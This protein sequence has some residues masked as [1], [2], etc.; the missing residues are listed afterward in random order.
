VEEIEAFSRLDRRAIL[1]QAYERRF[2][3]RVLDAIALHKPTP[4]PERP[5]FQAMFC[6]DE[7]EESLRR[8]I[9]ELAPDA[10]T[11]AVA[12]FYFI[13]MYYRGAN[14]AHF[15]PLCPAV[16]RPSHWVAEQVV[17]GHA[18]D[19]ERRARTRRALGWAS[20]QFHLGSRGVAAGA[21]LSGAVG[22]LASL[23]LVARTFFPRLTARL[24]QLFGRYVQAPPATR[25]QIERGDEAPGPENGRLGFTLDERV[26]IAERVLRDLG[27]THFARLVFTF[28]HGSTSMNNPHESA[29]DCGA[30][31][32]ARGGPNGRAMAQMFNEPEVRARLAQR[33]IVIPAETVFVGGMHNTSSETITLYDVDRVPESHCAEFN[34]IRAILEQAG[35]RDAHERSRRFESAPL[36]H[37][38][39]AARQHVEGRAEDLAQVRP[40]WGHATNAINIV[41]RRHWTRGLFMDRRAFMTSY[42]PAQDDAENTILTRILQAVFPVCAGISLEYYFSYVDNTGWGCGTKLPHNISALV[43]VMDGAASDLRT[44]LPW[45]MVEIHEP[46]RLLNI[47]ETTPEAMLRIMDRNPG[48][49]RLCRNG[50][51]YLAVLHPQTRKLSMFRNG[52]FEEYQP[53]ATSL[54]TAASSVEWYRGWRDHLEFAEIGPCSTPTCS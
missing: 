12:G 37:S 7:R 13:A 40:E 26:A 19:H 41:G 10:E 53:Q 44:G 42:D 22:V 20:H 46:V 31:G 24:R 52:R 25:L 33:G 21:L 50:W 45:Q 35:D 34:A 6:L 36:T 15:L 23:P 39:G 32:G 9:E 30:C 29:H 28:G 27:I 3:T 4:T 47:I 17:D 5:R 51:V 11:F 2:N 43:G 38:F 1:H 54:P 48:I 16:I 18:D 8:H 14:D 49:G